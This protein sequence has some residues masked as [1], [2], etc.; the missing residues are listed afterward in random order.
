MVARCEGSH[1]RHKCH[2][3]SSL[4][5]CGMRTAF[6]CEL[7]IESRRWLGSS[8][9][10]AVDQREPLPINEKRST[11]LGTRRP[12]FGLEVA[13]CSATT[14]GHGKALARVVSGRD[15]MQDHGVQ[16]RW[17][18]L[19]LPPPARTLPPA[20]A[21]QHRQHLARSESITGL[22]RVIPRRGGSI[23]PT[24]AN[25]TS[26]MRRGRRSTPPRPERHGARSGGC[27]S[28]SRPRGERPR[29]G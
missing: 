23:S 16:T 18:P 5:S 14:L 4:G 25:P 2:R 3:R 15:C 28:N 8:W 13:A 9:F 24:S 26:T 1:V 29:S 7:L 6:R 22:R 20:D 27:C 12:Q 19:F 11:S 17:P 10:L 21:R